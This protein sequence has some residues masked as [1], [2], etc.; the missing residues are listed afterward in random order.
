MAALTQTPTAYIARIYYLCN[1]ELTTKMLDN[2]AIKRCGSDD[3]FTLTGEEVREAKLSP[4]E[5][6]VK[7]TLFQDWQVRSRACVLLPKK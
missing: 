2:E 4:R 3:F 6:P 7:I 5:S 1:F